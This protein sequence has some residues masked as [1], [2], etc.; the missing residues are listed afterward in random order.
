MDGQ[1]GA[2]VEMVQLVMAILV[3]LAMAVAM[4]VTSLLER[5]S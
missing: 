2:A 1:I 5:D 4:A 3:V